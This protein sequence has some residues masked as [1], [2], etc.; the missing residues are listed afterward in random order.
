MTFYAVPF[1]ANADTLES[2]GACGRNHTGGGDNTS[3]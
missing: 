3:A 1:D 2:K